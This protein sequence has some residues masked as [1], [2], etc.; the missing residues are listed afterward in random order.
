[1]S[2]EIVTIEYLKNQILYLCDLLEEE[3]VKEPL[4]IN[5]CYF[6]DNSIRNDFT[7][8]LSKWQ[9]ISGS[10]DEPPYY[11]DI[12]TEEELDKFNSAL[13]HDPPPHLR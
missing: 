4:D 9:Q 5:E 10:A 12:F 7:V 8:L 2:E 6:L 11:G 1:M 13:I 3:K